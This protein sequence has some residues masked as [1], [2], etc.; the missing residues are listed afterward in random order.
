MVLKRFKH[1]YTNYEKERVRYP[2]KRGG[3]PI[4]RG[5]YP[6]KRGRYPINPF[7]SATFLCLF[8][9]NSFSLRAAA[10]SCRF[11]YDVWNSP[12]TRP[13]FTYPLKAI[14]ITIRPFWRDCDHRHLFHSKN[15]WPSSSVRKRRMHICFEWN[16][17]LW[18]WHWNGK[19]NKLGLISI[20]RVPSGAINRL[21]NFECYISDLCGVF[22]Y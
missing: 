16:K 8:L 21:K 14:L 6:I 11:I 18:L 22:Q 17:C 5:R 12:Y 2:I 10:A 7:N 4:K 13:S 1:A 20:P 9:T 19:N 3:Y 15:I